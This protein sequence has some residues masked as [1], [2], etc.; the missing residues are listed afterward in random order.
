MT[1]VGELSKECETKYGQTSERLSVRATRLK[2]IVKNFH[3][4]L[5]TSQKVFSSISILFPESWWKRNRL[6]IE[7]PKIPSVDV[8]PFFLHLAHQEATDCKKLVL[9]GNYTFTKGAN[10]HDVSKYSLALGLILY[11][12]KFKSL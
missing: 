7:L 10:K 2:E 6:I 12:E 3:W 8:F 4:D 9:Y 5:L 11:S 1:V